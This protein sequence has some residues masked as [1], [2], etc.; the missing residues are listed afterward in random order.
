VNNLAVLSDVSADY[1]PPGGS[2]ISVS[3]LGEP[4]IPD[5]ELVRAVRDQMKEWFGRQAGAWRHLR[6]YRIPH[7]LPDQT[8]VG[9]P[10]RAT[11]KSGRFLCGDD[12]GTASL[13]TAMASGRDAAERALAR[14]AGRT[15]DAV[16]G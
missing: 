16:A 12:M 1:A 13:Q 2:L 15:V 8:T 5:D 14:L 6:T 10:D 9:A 4:A 3:I 7:A 11:S